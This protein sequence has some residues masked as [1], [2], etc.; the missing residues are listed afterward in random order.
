MNWQSVDPRL[1]LVSL[2]PKSSVPVANPGSPHSWLGKRNSRSL[3]IANSLVCGTAVNNQLKPA[4][5]SGAS[6]DPKYVSR[7]PGQMTN[8]ATADSTLLR[9]IVQC[10]G[11]DP[12]LR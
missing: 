9:A 10:R 3:E 8:K 2:G 1:S 12:E 6:A 5:V 11:N 7:G 4:A